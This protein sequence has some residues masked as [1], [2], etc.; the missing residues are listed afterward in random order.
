MNKWNFNLT[1]ADHTLLDEC[2]LI[3]EGEWQKDCAHF[4][5]KH[6]DGRYFI[7]LMGDQQS[8]WTEGIMEVTEA[9]VPE[10]I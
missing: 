4:A 7:T 3:G 1:E 9:E 8:V 6:P 10:Y 2:E 5:W